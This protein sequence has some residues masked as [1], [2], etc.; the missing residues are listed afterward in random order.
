MTL[1]GDGTESIFEG[2]MSVG[3]KVDGLVLS[4]S[5]HVPK[6]VCLRECE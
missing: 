2:K 5:I 4:M 1:T 6:T 3:W